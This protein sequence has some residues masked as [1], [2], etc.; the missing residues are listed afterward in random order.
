MLRFNKEIAE[1]RESIKQVI[2]EREKTGAAITPDVFLV[3]SRSLVAAAD[4]RFDELRRLEVLA[5]DARS[6][7][8][9]TTDSTARAAIVNEAQANM[10][11]IQE[12]S[13]ARMA[14]EYERGAVL[15][16]F[17]AEQLKGIESS[18]FDIANFFPDMIASFDPV[19]EI[20]R[21]AEFAEV[22]QRVLAE[23]Q[24]R[25]AK[26]SEI[27][28]PTYSAAE[29]AKAATLVKKL[30]DVEELLRLKD[31]TNAEARLKELFSDFPR[32]PRVF[33]ALAQTA[34]LAAQ[35]ATDEDVQ[36]ERLRRA[37]ANYR[38]ALE[39][40]TPETD[41]ALISRAHEAMGR[42]YAFMEN[43]G[44]ASKEFEAAIRIGNVRGGA[45]NEALAGKKRL[46]QP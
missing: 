39:A 2:T 36:A 6:R 4:A 12:A 26:A 30:S 24:A 16:F 40:S 8:D 42:I 46:E 45:Y 25:M 7:L 44:E 37:L 20:R 43:P 28:M 35:D 1:R 13:I 21:P 15:V 19:K 10:T 31:Y 38:L 33:F 9:K 3:V 18:G 41:R 23:R 29:A 27:D 17:F 5:R 11:S 22:R 34:N 32:E 14:D